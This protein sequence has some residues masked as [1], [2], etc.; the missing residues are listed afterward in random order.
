[1]TP[2][3]LEADI[4]TGEELAGMGLPGAEAGAAGTA[5]GQQPAAGAVPAPAGGPAGGA[6]PT[7]G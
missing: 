7:P 6:T 2:A 4:T 3:D 1:M 5:P